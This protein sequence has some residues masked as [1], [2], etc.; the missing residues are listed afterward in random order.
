VA[1][2]GAVHGNAERTP[3]V[4]A[5]SVAG[6]DTPVATRTRTALD[7]RWPG[8]IRVAGD[9]ARAAAWLAM[10]RSGLPA[11]LAAALHAALLS[12]PTS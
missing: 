5:G 3:V 9:G 10:V 11:D 4:L 2:V 8:C 6:G 1:A 12:T 7:A